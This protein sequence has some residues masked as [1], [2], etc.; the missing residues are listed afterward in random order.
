MNVDAAVNSVNQVLQYCRTEFLCVE[1]ICVLAR[2]KI[3]AILQFLRSQF[4]LSYI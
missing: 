1:N 2:S 3:F 4:S